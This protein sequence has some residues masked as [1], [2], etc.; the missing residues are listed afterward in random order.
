MNIKFISC[1][2]NDGTTELAEQHATGK[3]N[4]AWSQWGGRGLGGPPGSATAIRDA[5]PHQ[6]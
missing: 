4:Y 3:K 2:I 6:L 1:L 5:S